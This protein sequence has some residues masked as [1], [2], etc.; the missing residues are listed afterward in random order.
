[1]GLTCQFG[2]GLIDMK[3]DWK[4]IPEGASNELPRGAYLVSNG[5]T[6]G[7]FWNRMRG[8]DL[9][10]KER[11]LCGNK[12]IDWTHYAEIENFPTITK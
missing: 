1:M 8:K 12:G 5:N 6:V 2:K 7:I 10:L 4:P 3:I 9:C 11:R